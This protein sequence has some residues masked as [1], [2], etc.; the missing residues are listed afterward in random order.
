EP[1]R[2]KM[3]GHPSASA[4]GELADLFPDRLVPSEL[5]EIPEGWRVG[6]LSDQIEIL[7]GGT[8]KT[9]VPGYW[10][11]DVP[12]F[13]VVDAPAENEVFVTRTEKSITS[14]GLD[15]SAA[16]VLPVN[17]TIV[18]A[19]GTVGKLALTGVPMAFNQSCYGIR[20]NG[21]RGE[22]YTYYRMQT[23]LAQL[24]SRTHGSVFSTITRATFEA[25]PAVNPP[26]LVTRAFDSTVQPYLVRVRLYQLEADVLSKLRDLLLPRLVSGEMR[27][28]SIS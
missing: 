9:A 22:Y 13:S 18:S 6:R 16:Q 2:A 3:A 8:P 11:G 4:P 15:N 28:E 1:V 7:G 17:S 14:A 21:G 26:D 23:S 20:P 5:G 25:V 27:P 24:R 19:R 10:D 12:W